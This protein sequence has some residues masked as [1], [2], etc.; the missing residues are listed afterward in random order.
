MAAR[1][2][3]RYAG[4][5]PYKPQ[6]WMSDPK[7]ACFGADVDLFFHPEH[8]TG[9]PKAARTAAAK[10]VCAACPFETTCR[11]WA[12]ET[13]QSDGV[14]GGEDEDERKTW[15]RRQQPSRRKEMAA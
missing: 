9:Q 10:A 6:Q 13:R 4:H 2:Q 15:L 5:D 12:R 7:R 1:T 14:W 8:E 11:D 3:P